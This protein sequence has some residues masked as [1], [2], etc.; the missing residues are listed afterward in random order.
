MEQ[1]ELV[2][3]PSYL[4]FPIAG[5]VGYYTLCFAA[6]L[7]NRF[8]FQFGVR[9]RLRELELGL[10]VEQIHRI[11]PELVVLMQSEGK[12]PRFS[13][14]LASPKLWPEMPEDEV[15]L[16]CYHRVPKPKRF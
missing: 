5:V 1:T 9:M 15:V 2:F 16:D 14:N 12:F 7:F 10:N 3:N 8:T 4:F 11:M 13:F 6:Y